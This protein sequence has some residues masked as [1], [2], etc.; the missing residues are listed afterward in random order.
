MIKSRL[1]QAA[2]AFGMLSYAGVARAELT[3]NHFVV[4]TT[5]D[6]AALCNSPK[7]DRLYTAAVN[8]CQ[9]FGVGTYGAFMAVQKANPRIHAFCVPDSVTRDQAGAAFVAWVG[10]DPDRSALP[11]TDGIAAFLHETYP[12]PTAKPASAKGKSK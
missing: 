11:P 1:V 12:C 3:E 7:T 9:G 6:L 4:R 10:N 5:G 8:F 2:F